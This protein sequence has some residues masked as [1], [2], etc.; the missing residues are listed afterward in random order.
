LLNA[1]ITTRLVSLQLSKGIDDVD[2]A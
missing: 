1:D 2:T